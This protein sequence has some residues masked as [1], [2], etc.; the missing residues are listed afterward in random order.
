M[1]LYTPNHSSLIVKTARW[2][3]AVSRGRI[4]SPV[5]E[6]FDCLHVVFFDAQTLRLAVEAAGFEVLRI[7]TWPYDPSRSGQARGFAKT[8]FRAL[9]LAAPAAGGR[10]RL[11]MVARAA[12]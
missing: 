2:L 5:A 4:A 6:I 1:I 7:E 12:A 9:E 11:M 8:A 10:F 3:H